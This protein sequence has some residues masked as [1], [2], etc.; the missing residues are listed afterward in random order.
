[1]KRFI[2]VVFAAIIIAGAAVYSHRPAQNPDPNHN[3]ADFAVWI[4][5]K[6]WDFSADKYMSKEYVEGQPLEREANPLRQYLHLHDGVGTVLHRHKPGLGFGDFLQSEG[7]AFDG[8][9]LTTDTGQKY[10]NDGQKT[11]KFY[12]NGKEIPMQANYVFA[13]TDQ[14]LLTYG[15][16]DDIQHELSSMTDI[17]CKYSKTCPWRGAP[18]TENCIADPTVPCVAQ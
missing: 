12:V 8:T 2:P 17:A 5:G 11:W 7:F 16:G 1:M 14:I 18:P 3:H 9:C 13:D 4:D 6:Q 15:A 10:C